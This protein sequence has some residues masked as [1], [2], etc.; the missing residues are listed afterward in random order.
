MLRW[1]RHEDHR[2]RDLHPH[3]TDAEADGAAIPAAQARRR[4]DR[5]RRG[6][7]GPRLQPGLRRRRGGGRARL[8]RDAP[9][10]RPPRRGSAL[11]RA[12]LGAHV[13]RRHGHQEAERRGLS[14]FFQSMREESVAKPIVGT[15]CLALAAVLMQTPCSAQDELALRQQINRTAAEALIRE[16]FD[17]LEAIAGEYR[18][19][20]A[21]TPSGVWKMAEFYK[22]ISTTVSNVRDEGLLL[23]KEARIR[24]WIERYPHSGLARIALGITLINHGWFYR[25]IKYSTQTPEENWKPF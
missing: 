19:D 22:G 12:A 16:D 7:E 8:S 11:R 5:D 17:K 4:G 9:R 10:A 20:H 18:K 3:G 24:K 13:P 23:E 21:R 15:M 1:Q 14:S 6:G 2:D 25:G